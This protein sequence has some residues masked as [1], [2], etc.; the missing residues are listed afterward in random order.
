MKQ[1]IFFILA[2]SIISCK[3]KEEPTPEVKTATL[4]VYYVTEGDIP[5]THYWFNYNNEKVENTTMPVSGTYQIIYQAEQK[6]NIQGSITNSTSA[7]KQIKVVYNHDTIYS[8]RQ[9]GNIAFNITL[10]AL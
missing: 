4:E 5:N 1:I 9:M 3:K 7:R 10:P 2:I 6:K 8:V